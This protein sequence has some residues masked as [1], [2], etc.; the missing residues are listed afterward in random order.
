MESD[1]TEH[2]Y[3]LAP[4]ILWTAPYHYITNN[5]YNITTV[6]HILLFFSQIKT[7]DK[8]YVLYV[9]MMHW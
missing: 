3:R 6:C 8:S 5:I 7:P 2:V 9:T 4:N 1:K